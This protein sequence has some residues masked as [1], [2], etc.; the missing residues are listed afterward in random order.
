M[1]NVNTY[2][3]VGFTIISTVS[4]F[5]YV[6]MKIHHNLLKLPEKEV[7]LTESQLYLQK[8]REKFIQC[9]EK[10]VLNNNIQPDFYIKE[11]Y[12]ETINKKDNLLESSWKSRILFEN[13]PQGM[14]V[15]FYNAY[16]RGF[17]YY[18]DTNISYPFLNAVAMKY[19]TQ[20]HCRDF[21][22]DDAVIPKDH[23]TP[24]L[25]I[26]EIEVDK[27]KSKTR[28]DV[29]KGPF[30]KLKKYDKPKAKIME[31]KNQKS[32]QEEPTHI[33]NKFICMGKNYKFSPLEKVVPAETPNIEKKETIPMNYSSFKQWHNPEK[34]DL[35]AT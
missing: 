8:T 9:Y 16:K 20:F 26:H 23:S 31:T 35:I 28:I 32:Q 11:Q 24:F 13:T 22:I 4:F 27:T 30:A 34:F 15:M 6:Y 21:F 18:S 12:N 17:S 14:V 7:V 19:V 5:S 2:N 29:N 33:K 3:F 1:F 25:R 10:E